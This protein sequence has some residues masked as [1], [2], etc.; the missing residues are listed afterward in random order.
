MSHARENASQENLQGVPAGQAPHGFLPVR[1][2]RGAANRAVPILHHAVGRRSQALPRTAGARTRASG[3]Q[4]ATP[5]TRPQ[6][7]QRQRVNV[8]GRPPH[9]VE[10]IALA[11]PPLAGNKYLAWQDS[12]RL[13]IGAAGIERV[14]GPVAVLIQAALPEKPRDLETITG[15]LLEALAAGGIIESEDRAVRI[16]SE[17]SAE[18]PRGTAAVEVRQVVTPE[19]R[20]KYASAARIREVARRMASAAA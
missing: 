9:R 19:V 16:V 2:L 14:P 10:E 5:K 13:M 1:L 8:G 18:I 4:L 7:M 11:V 17:W 15:P 12:V 20:Q 3:G 6:K